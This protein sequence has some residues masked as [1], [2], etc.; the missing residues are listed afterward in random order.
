MATLGQAESA[1]VEVYQGWPNSRAV[2]IRVT[3]FTLR[4]G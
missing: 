4:M 2:L 3:Q 1:K